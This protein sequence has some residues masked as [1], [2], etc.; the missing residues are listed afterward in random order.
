M[1]S[2]LNYYQG[3][4]VD[5]LFSELFRFLLT[6]RSS[7]F[8]KAILFEQDADGRQR[9][10]IFYCDAMQ[11]TQKHAPFLIIRMSL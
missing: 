5:A 7:E 3:K 2:T 6:V 9:L 10:N 8:E 1:S 4:L 11:S